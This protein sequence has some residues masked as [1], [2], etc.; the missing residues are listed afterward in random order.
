MAHVTLVRHGQANTTARDETSYDN[1]S[2]LGR[3]QSR[4]LGEHFVT[5]GER[6]ARV[7]CGTLNRHRQTAEAIGVEGKSAMVEDARLNELEY[8]TLAHLFQTQHGVAIPE[9]REG[10]VT[11]LPQLFTA[12]KDGKIADAPESFE[13]FEERVGTALHEITGGEGRAL[14]VTSGGLIG[15]AMR[16]TMGLGLDALA[17]ACLAIENTSVHRWQPLPTGLALTQFNALPHLQ[18][19]ER[20][21][22]R[23]H[24]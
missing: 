14:V 12:W 7:Y 4:W 24:L 11:H 3:Q 2:D 19:P 9:D 15:M 13:A 10:F 17:H 6:F 20:Q 5:S 18:S 22:A 1:L 8:F 21:F 23:S 16:V